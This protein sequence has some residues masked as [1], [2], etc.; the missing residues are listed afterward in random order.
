M[1]PSTATA[2]DAPPV[3]LTEWLRMF[4]TRDWSIADQI[5]A[6]DYAPLYPRSDTLPGRDAW[7]QRQASSSL[8]GMFESVEFLLVSFSV[9]GDTIFY[10]ADMHGEQ[11]GGKGII[12]PMIGI[13]QTDSAVITGAHGAL[14][15][16]AMY[17]QM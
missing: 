14:D 3:L 1:L 10:L 11:Y 5:I 4:T 7:K 2:Q 13:L 9:T 15:E 17:D 12:A 6:A 16:E 8:F